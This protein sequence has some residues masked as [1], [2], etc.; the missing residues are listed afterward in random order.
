MLLSTTAW[1][2]VLSVG[3]SMHEVRR[4]NARSPIRRSVLGWKRRSRRCWKSM[5]ECW[6]PATYVSL[7]FENGT[8]Y[9]PSY[10]G[11]RIGTRIYQPAGCSL[12]TINVCQHYFTVWKLVYTTQITFVRLCYQS[13]LYDIDTQYGYCKLLSDQIYY[14]SHAVPFWITKHC[15][16]LAQRSKLAVLLSSN[17]LASINVV[18]VRQ[19][20]LVLGWVTVCGRVNHFGM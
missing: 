10:N 18:A 5:M 8:R 15:T 7:Y 13:F 12:M 11:R 17:A 4:Q 19:T 3:D 1:V 16:V 6:W 20:R 14:L 2:S 9:G